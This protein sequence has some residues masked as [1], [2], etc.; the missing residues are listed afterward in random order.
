MKP[1]VPIGQPE[2]EALT[3]AYENTKTPGDFIWVG[4]DEATLLGRRN[5][6]VARLSH[7]GDRIFTSLVPAMRLRFADGTDGP[8]VNIDAR[9]QESLVFKR[10]P[11]VTLTAAQKASLTGAYW[12][13]EL[14]TTFR[15]VEGE[16]GGLTLERARR[17]DPLIPLTPRAFV[18]ANLTVKLTDEG[19]VVETGRLR[20]LRF[21]RARP[22]A[23]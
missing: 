7:I 9:D 20:D 1:P 3:G 18:A 13:D 5:G 14:N 4:R 6:P 10:V 11:P 22:P 23:R 21:V 12:S 19:L 16:K 2:L 8:T 15:I 17:A